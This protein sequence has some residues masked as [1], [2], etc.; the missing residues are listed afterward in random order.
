MIQALLESGTTSTGRS[1]DIDSAAAF[2]A[3]GGE[4]VKQK[5][6]IVGFSRQ[7]PR[8]IVYSPGLS[9]PSALCRIEADFF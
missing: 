9:V 6:R 2:P 3:K 8:K 4:E 1:R 7:N 5:V